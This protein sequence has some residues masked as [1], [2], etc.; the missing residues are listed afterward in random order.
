[1]KITRRIFALGTA[2]A[3]LLAIPAAL[4]DTEEKA[5]PE[6]RIYMLRGLFGIFSLGIDKLAAKL[7]AQGYD[8]IILGWEQWSLAATEI[9]ANHRRGETGHT[10]LIGHSLGSDSTVQ[11]ANSVAPQKI[12]IDLIVTF[13]ITEPL[14]VPANVEFFINYYQNNG[15]GRRAIAGPGFR[16][17]LDN[18]DLSADHSLD[19]LNI[20]ESDKLQQLVVARVFDVT[21]QQLQQVP[22]RRKT[23]SL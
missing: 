3:G 20:D 1:M 12:P 8:P 13:D 21:F 14:E 4:A 2:L 19:H 11:I 22:A 7:R 18:V 16:G 10:I 15:V 5:A 17:Q 6:A 23:R 9:V